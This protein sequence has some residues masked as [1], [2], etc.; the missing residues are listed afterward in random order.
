MRNFSGLA[1]V[2]LAVGMCCASAAPANATNILY[3]SDGNVGFDNM[4]AA[5]GSLPGTYNVT[6]ASDP[7]NFDSLLTGG[8]FNL[9]IFAQQDFSGYSTEF[10]NI[11]AFVAGG[12]SA[13][14][15]DWD[16]SDSSNIAPL[17]AT[18]TGN[19]NDTSVS[20]TYPAFAAGLGSNPMSLFNP[21]WGIFSTGLLPGSGSTVA[22][23]FGGGDAAIVIGP[24]G[25]SIINGMLTDTFSSSADGQQL[26]VNEIVSLSNPTA[27]V[28]E[29]GSLTV[30]GLG[31]ASVVGLG[32]M[33][34]RNAKVAAV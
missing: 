1:T 17:G 18:F 4:G 31:L 22:A 29:P 11:A 8:G 7:S 21:G 25:R 30:L 14:V 27:V 12:G 6:T 2:A 33:K 24:T 13:I 19:A 5:L 16:I 23:T 10:A 32:W 26:Y 9:A 34:K 20:V 3:F 15:N 28:P